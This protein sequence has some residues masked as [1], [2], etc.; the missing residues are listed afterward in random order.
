MAQMDQKTEKE[1]LKKFYKLV[2]IVKAKICDDIYCVCVLY[3][4]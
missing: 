3:I 4:L 1:M 2:T